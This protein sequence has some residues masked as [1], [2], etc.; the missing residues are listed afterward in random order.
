MVH[1]ILNYVGEDLYTNVLIYGVYEAAA[2][3]ASAV[4]LLAKSSRNND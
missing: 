1:D 2:A 4:A 3:V